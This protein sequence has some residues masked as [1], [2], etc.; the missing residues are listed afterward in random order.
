V[1]IAGIFGSLLMANNLFLFVFMAF[2]KRIRGYTA[3]SWM[4]RRQVKTAGEVL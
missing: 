1:V 2:G 3:R 4:G